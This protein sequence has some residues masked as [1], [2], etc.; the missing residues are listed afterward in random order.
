MQNIGIVVT[1]NLTLANVHDN[2]VSSCWRDSTKDQG[3][4]GSKAPTCSPAGLKNLSHVGVTRR[5][6]KALR[7]ARRQHTRPPA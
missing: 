3:F 6:I 4:A 5:R 7:A 2:P 1:L